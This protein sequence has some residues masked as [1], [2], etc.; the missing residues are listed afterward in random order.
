MLKKFFGFSN[1]LF[2]NS[3]KLMGFVVLSAILLGIVSYLTLSLFYLFDREW[4]APIILSPSSERVIQMNSQLVQQKY[5]RDKL[6]VERI[7]LEMQL[8]LIERT[9]A[10]NS[11]FQNR[12]KSAVTSDLQA[13]QKELRG[14]QS[15]YAE[16]RATKKQVV[17]ANKAFERLNETDLQKDLAAGLIEEEV[18]VRNKY[19]LSQ[20][21]SQQISYEQKQLEFESRT[22]ELG[23]RI[24]AL[25]ALDEKLGRQ[26]PA[27]GDS[28]SYEV[29]L[30]EQEYQRSLLEMEELTAQKIPIEKQIALLDSSL[31]EYDKILG[32][33]TL[34]PYYKA[35]NEKISIAFV[36]YSN[37]QNVKAG[38]PIY[39]CSLELIWCREVGSVRQVLDG[40]VSARHPMFSSDLRG[41][42]VEIELKDMAWAEEKALHVDSRPL[43]I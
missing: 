14:L 19:A 27:N 1:N 39:G 21:I 13:K 8:N 17:E 25:K 12:F 29:L 36:P 6:K 23:R 18:Y 3:Y 42:M 38:A 5:N 35:M 15:L 33:I 7:T 41:V 20:N 2:V 4:I 24:E 9:I 43:L 31:T 22:I 37:L 26:T 28:S 11:E 40:E 34:S 10:V 30:M 16:Y 32:T